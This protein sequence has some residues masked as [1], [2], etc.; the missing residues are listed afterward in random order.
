MKSRSST[1][2][3]IYCFTSDTGNSSNSIV[4]SRSIVRNTRKKIKR[5]RNQDK[6][7]EI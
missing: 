7:I 6:R 3:E 1:S 2:I 4:K 5:D